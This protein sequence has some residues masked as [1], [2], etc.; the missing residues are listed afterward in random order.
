MR[1]HLTQTKGEGQA[2]FAGFFCAGSDRLVMP[3]GA[4]TATEDAEIGDPEGE[5]DKP[6]GKGKAGND[7][8]AGRHPFIAGL[9]KELPPEGAEWTTVERKKWLQAAA[10]IFD[11]IYKTGAVAV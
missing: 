10:M 2:R 6:K 3:K 1:G 8:G 9:L 5:D 4:T 11:L 7:D